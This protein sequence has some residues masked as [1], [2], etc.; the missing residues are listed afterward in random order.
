M[1]LKW[2]EKHKLIDAA[3][4]IERPGK[5][6]PRDKYLT[7]DQVA[8]LQDAAQ[9][10]HVRLFVAVAYATAGRAG[11]VLG[12]TWDRCDF[13]RGKINL[14]DET[15]LTPHKGRAVV[16]MTNTVR[17]ELDRARRAAFSEYV[18]EWAGRRVASVKKGV[19]AAAK[20]AGLPRVSPHMLRHSAAV[21]MAEAGVP[22]EEIASYL[23]HTDVRL[24][25]RIYARFSPDALR[26]AAA[27]LEL[28]VRD[29]QETPT[30][31]SPKS[32][33]FMVGA[34]GIEP[35]TPTMST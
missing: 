31:I 24:T 19:A 26:N 9:M 18:I 15:I 35:V 32:L 2:A 10:P 17:M 3:P 12:L 8:A 30:Q 5:P 4:A 25:R 28:P 11:A 34:T 27:A 7:R 21:H 13:K 20:N 22:F 23:G 33:S 16:P 6:K 14:E 29:D 1:V